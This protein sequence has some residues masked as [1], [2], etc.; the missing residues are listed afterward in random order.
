MNE[1][2]KIPEWVWI[3]VQDPE[4]Q[5][6]FFG[7]HDER[8]NVSYIPTF[9][10]KEDA[11]QCFDQFQRVQGHK[12]EIQAILYQALAEDAFRNGFSIFL[13]GADGRIVAKIP[14][15]SE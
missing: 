10:Q 12:Y 6:Q 7:L 1:P 15:Q 2:M 13:L 9:F 11:Q 8:S 3:I 14:P 4:G 5:E